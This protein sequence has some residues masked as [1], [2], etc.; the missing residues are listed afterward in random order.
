MD[1]GGVQRTED[2]KSHPEGGE[3]V[4]GSRLAARDLAGEHHRRQEQKQG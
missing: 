1:V 2:V 4:E 3:Q